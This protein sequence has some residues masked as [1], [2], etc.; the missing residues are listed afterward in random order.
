MLSNRMS[1]L[2]LHDVII[3]RLSHKVGTLLPRWRH[4]FVELPHKVDI[5][6]YKLSYLDTLSREVDINSCLQDVDTL[7]VDIL[8]PHD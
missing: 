6:L 3:L 4:H 2:Y 8:F 1:T 5:L 7:I